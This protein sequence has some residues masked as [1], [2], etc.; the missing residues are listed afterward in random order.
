MI[1]RTLVLLKPDSIARGLVGTIITRFENVGLKIVASKMVW[2]DGDHAGKHYFD[3]KER[4]GERVFDSLKDYLTEGPVLALVLQG[5]SSVDVVRKLIGSTY[6]SDAMPGTIRG[7][8]AH[9]SKHYA[10][11]NGKRV[12]NLIHASANSKEAEY[13]INLWFKPEE[14]H[15]YSTIF[16]T[17]TQ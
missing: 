9:I 13:E 12:G 4:H 5:V 1:E 7:D 3:V 8:Y 14:I 16:E 17:Q 11:V 15:S 2:V 6:P 10:N